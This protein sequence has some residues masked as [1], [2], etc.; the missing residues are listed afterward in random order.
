MAYLN[1][2]KALGD[3][4]FLGLNADTSV[5]K[6]KGE[7]R[8]INPEEE[9]KFILENLKAVDCVEIFSEDTPYDLI[10]A[11]SPHILVKGGDWK[12]EQIVGCDIVK[13]SG[14]IVKSLQ[15]KEGLSTTNTIEKIK[16]Q[17][18]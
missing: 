6:L 10:K 17:T 11:V 18:C 12:E 15:F 4:L 9:R 2:A 13:A 1:E 14:G 5:K 3:L 7:K 16:G 8:P